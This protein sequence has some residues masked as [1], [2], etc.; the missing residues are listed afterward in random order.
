MIDNVF[1]DHA[2]IVPKTRMFPTKWDDDEM[3][4]KSPP[5]T[6]KRSELDDDEALKHKQIEE[7]KRILT[8][9]KKHA[10]A[11]THTEQPAGLSDLL[12]ALGT[13]SVADAIERVKE[14]QFEIDR[15]SVML[16]DA[17]HDALSG[18]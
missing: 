1:A 10:D 17:Y 15:L 6:L 12:A 7:F 9:A 18:I 13:K 8:E 3:Y 2:V 5:K 11:K 4:K 16:Q 14:L